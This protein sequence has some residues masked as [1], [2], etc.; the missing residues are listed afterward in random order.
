VL[1]WNQFVEL[2]LFVARW[3]R[4]VVQGRRFL[5]PGPG[6]SSDVAIEE[7]DEHAIAFLPVPKQVREEQE[8]QSPS[9]EQEIIQ[10][11]AFVWLDVVSDLM[12][13][14]LRPRFDIQIHDGLAKAVR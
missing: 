11:M 8:D 12:A 5:G 3:R 7:F 13:V 14:F 4:V 6:F 10:C 1:A 9:D 2:V